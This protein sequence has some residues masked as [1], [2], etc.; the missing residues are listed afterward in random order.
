M[1]KNNIKKIGMGV[2]LLVILFSP[3]LSAS[4][5]GEEIKRESYIV[6]RDKVVRTIAQG[7]IFEDN[8]EIKNL[9]SVPISASFSVSGETVDYVEFEVNG[10]EIPIGNTSYITFLVKGLQLGIIL[11]KY[12]LQEMLKKLFL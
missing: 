6:S 9:R 2:F 11:E 10:L 7:E 1:R 8:I 4:A 5:Y 12:Q 3:F